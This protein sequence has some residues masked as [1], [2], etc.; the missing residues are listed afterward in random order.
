MTAFADETSG[1]GELLGSAD[2]LSGFLGSDP[3]K[4]TYSL[5]AQPP[6]E[7]ANPASARTIAIGVVDSGVN[8][9]HPQIAPYLAGAKSF[10]DE[11]AEDT[12]GHGTAVAATAM[13]ASG[14]FAALYSAKVT[15]SGHRPQVA[16]VVDAIE[17]LAAVDVDVINMSLGFDPSVAEVHSICASI[18]RHPTIF[19]VV[20]AG[21]RGP[22]WRPIPAAC[23]GP[24]IMVTASDEPSSGTGSVTAPRPLAVNRIGFLVAAAQARLA[25][26]DDQGTVS[27]LD[28]VLRK[29]PD[30]LSALYLDAAA[31]FR[32]GQTQEALTQTDR[33]IALS[34]GTPAPQ[35]LWLN[36]LAAAN[37]ADAPKAIAT[38]Q[39]LLDI[40]P[41]DRRAAELLAFL[42]Q[43]DI[44]LPN[45]LAAF[46][47]KEE[48]P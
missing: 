16:A 39:R 30:H 7:L 8:F 38:L 6:P 41:G 44:Q 26:G 17:W 45:A 33:L 11:G 28:E 36:A 1:H 47:E 40:A 31:R 24:N 10:T 48:D 35:A 21:N 9:L 27:M 4:L 15:D 43:P 29:D 25:A 13:S 14:G 32:L 23:D 2:D 12:I 19:F 18:A 5:A 22:D 42:Q 3:D 20:A 34:A 46:F 37:L